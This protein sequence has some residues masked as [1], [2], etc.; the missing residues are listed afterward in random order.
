MSDEPPVYICESPMALTNAE[1]QTRYRARHRIGTMGLPSMVWLVYTTD[2]GEPP[3]AHGFYD[4]ERA[5][6]W[7]AASE[8]RHMKRAPIKMK[9]HIP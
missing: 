6:A 3:Y 7:A 2:P 1:R 5:L 8:H 9:D 4:R